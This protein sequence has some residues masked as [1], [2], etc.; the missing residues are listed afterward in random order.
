MIAEDPV[1]VCRDAKGSINVLLNSCRHRGLAVC[2]TDRGNTKLFHCPYH[3]WTYGRDGKLTGVPKMGEA[4][5]RELDKGTHSLLR[6]PRVEIYKGFIFA[7]WDEDAMSLEESLGAEM[8]WYLDIPIVGALGGLEVIGPAMK[9]RMKTN[10]K[11]AA[12]N[13]TG[14]DY[15]VL[16]THGCAFEIGFLPDYATLADYTANFDNGH[17]MGDIPKPGRAI[18]NDRNMAQMFGPEGASYV[19]N[20]NKRLR[21]HLSDRQGD[22]HDIGQSN[23]FPNLSWISFGCFHAFGL[24][25]WHPRGVDEIEVWQTTFFDAGAPQAI[26]DYARTQMSQENAA[27]GIFG[28]D[29]GENFERIAE[30]LRGKVAGN[31]DFDYSMGVGH[32]GEVQVSGLPGRLG[33]HY[34]EENH[35]NFYRHWIKMMSEKEG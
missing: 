30:V 3:G 9:F 25:Q 32:A 28:Q 34:T 11:L 31:M 2:S 19:E 4:Y 18:E 8:L 5:F 10:W 29:D 27:A 22:V 17:G 21:E 20:V 33:P 35:R 14:D 12:E 13:F 7:N 6:V 24:F 15:H 16:T 23:I 1:I 26:K